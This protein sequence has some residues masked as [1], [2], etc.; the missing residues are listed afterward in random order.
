MHRDVYNVMRGALRSDFSCGFGTVTTV[1]STVT[2]T[3]PLFPSMNRAGAGAAID[4]PSQHGLKP[5]ARTGLHLHDL[6]YVPVRE[7]HHGQGVGSFTV[8]A[9]TI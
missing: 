2:P 1:I 9:F 7:G 8:R 6:V 4:T 3:L 5:A